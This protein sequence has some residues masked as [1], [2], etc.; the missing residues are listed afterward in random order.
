MGSAMRKSVYISLL[1]V[2]AVFPA[3]VRAQG[4]KLTPREQELLNTVQALE[5]RLGELEKQVST[6]KT[7]QPAPQ[8][9]AKEEAKGEKPQKSV[10]ER[11]AQLEED[12][13]GSLKTFWK[14]GLRLE[15]PDGQFKLQLGGRLFFD[16]VWFSQDAELK[17]SLGDEQDGTQIRMGRL[18]MQGDIYQ[19]FFY[20]LEYEFAGNNGPGGPSDGACGS[21]LGAPGKSL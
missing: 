17:N 18:N 9:A 14:D 10:E 20:R 1:L 15:S 13:K 21:L 4:E 12:K 8:P 7:A 5:K 6:L 3:G 2:T 19:D 16:W 11:V